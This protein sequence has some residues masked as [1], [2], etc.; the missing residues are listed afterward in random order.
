MTCIIFAKLNNGIGIFIRP[1]YR[2]SLSFVPL[3][4]F[5]ESYGPWKLIILWKIQFSVLSFRNDSGK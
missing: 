1:S 2:S 5:C 4:D 3:N